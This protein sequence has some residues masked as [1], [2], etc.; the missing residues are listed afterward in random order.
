MVSSTLLYNRLIRG[1]LHLVDLQ[2]QIRL[3]HKSSFHVCFPKLDANFVNFAPSPSLKLSVTSLLTTLVN[4]YTAKNGDWSIAAVATALI[5]GSCAGIMVVL[6]LIYYHLL[7]L[8][9]AERG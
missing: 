3:A 7:K 8:K 6:L 5:T 1:L 9:K 2:E 4:V